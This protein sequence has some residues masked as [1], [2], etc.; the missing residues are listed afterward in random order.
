[1]TTLTWDRHRGHAWSYDVVALG[2]NYRIDEIRAAI[3]RVQ[4]RKLARNNE[5]RRHLT[6]LYRETLSEFAPDIGL[7]FTDAPGISACHLFP[8]LLPPKT[9]RQAFME[10]MKSRGIQ[11]S[12]H[13]PPTHQFVAYAGLAGAALPVTE[14]VASRE[15][16]LP[17][18]PA[19]TEDLVITVSQAVRAALKECS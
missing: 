11:T 10:A 14:D 9:S 12:I 18:Y 13:Y 17:L 15:V 7:P 8:I 3:G 2:Y 19:L 1:M 16:T 5:T 4:L 6:R